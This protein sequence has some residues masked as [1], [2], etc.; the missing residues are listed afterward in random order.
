MH[1]LYIL[2]RFKIIITSPTYYNIPRTIYV[3]FMGC[4]LRKAVG[5]LV[6]LFNDLQRCFTCILLFPESLLCII[7]SLHKR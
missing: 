1:R 4:C 2:A 6:R 7:D 3:E 5:F